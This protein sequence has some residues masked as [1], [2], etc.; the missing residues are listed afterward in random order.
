MIQ[1]REAWAASAAVAKAWMPFVETPARQNM[2]RELQELE[3]R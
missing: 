3:A 1:E 2:R